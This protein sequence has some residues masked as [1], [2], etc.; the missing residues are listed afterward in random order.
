MFKILV[1]QFKNSKRPAYPPPDL[2]EF[3]RTLITHKTYV[4]VYISKASESFL[5]LFSKL[6]RRYFQS[7]RSLVTTM[8]FKPAKNSK[9]EAVTSATTKITDSISEMKN[10]DISLK[11]LAKPGSK[12]S[13]IVGNTED[14]LE[15]KIGA[16]AVDGEANAELISF[17]SKVL[18]CRKSDL[19]LDRGSK[20]RSKVVTISKDSSLTIDRVR[21]IINSKLN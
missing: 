11:I 7:V 8:P 5:I 4:F 19:S 17:L 14:G 13:D 16:P 6:M 2:I 1:Q 18:G 10:G 3:H 15:V 21:E 9:K 20:N 12:E